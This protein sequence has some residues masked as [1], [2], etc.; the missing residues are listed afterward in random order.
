MST[1]AEGVRALSLTVSCSILPALADKATK[2]SRATAY[3]LI[4]HALVDSHSVR[5]IGEQNLDWYIV[6]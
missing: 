1:S 6:K 5:R 2:Q 3:R 4:R